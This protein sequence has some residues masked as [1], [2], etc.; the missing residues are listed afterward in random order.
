[1]GF[2]ILLLAFMVATA[3]TGFIRHQLLTLFAFTTGVLLI[4]DAWF[5]VM[6]AEDTDRLIAV[7]AATLG[8]LP[9]ATILIGGTLRIM[10][11]QLPPVVPKV[12]ALPGFTTETAPGWE[13]GPEA[14]HDRQLTARTF[15]AVWHSFR[16]KGSRRRPAASRHRSQS[17]S[18][19]IGKPQ[20]AAEALDPRR[21]PPGELWRPSMPLA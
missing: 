15:T 3:V 11:L 18:A 19:T 5:D 9:L 12:S 1:M 10:R 14:E 4:C 13:Q 7:L 8:E 17:R 21:C 20:T 6:T 16:N 2:D